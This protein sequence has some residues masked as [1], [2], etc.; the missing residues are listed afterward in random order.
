VKASIGAILLVCFAG[1]RYCNNKA[2]EAKYVG[3]YI[4]TSYPNCA[5]CSLHL[6]LNNYYE[7]IQGKTVRER[8]SWHYESGGDYW[9]VYINKDDQL[10][11]GRYAYL[12][13][14]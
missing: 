11:S 12:E 2:A 1:N 13:T 9:I 14:Q 6:Q 5:N 4:L 8:G 7:V 3:T 10:G